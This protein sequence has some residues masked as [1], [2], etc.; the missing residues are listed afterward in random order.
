DVTWLVCERECIPGQASLSLSLPVARGNT[1]PADRTKQTVFAA[2]RSDLPRP[3]PWRARLALEPEHLT[4]AVDAK[5]LATAAVRR[6]YFFP[7]A[8]TLVRHAAPQ[9]LSIV[10]DGLR[11]RL[12]RSPLSTAAP[13]DAGGVLLLEEGDGTTTTRR[14]FDLT[15]V[16]I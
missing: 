10:G 11:L 9:E 2:A 15:D 7:N 4:L 6:A 8:E 14:A 3:L 5:P 12:E 16:L 1:F 13:E